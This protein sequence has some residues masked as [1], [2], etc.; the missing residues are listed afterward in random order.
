MARKVACW[1]LVGPEHPGRKL[2]ER[3]SHSPHVSGIIQ[4]LCMEIDP[5][6]VSETQE[7]KGT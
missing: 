5:W 6:V 1:W 3:R 4:S 7:K 2:I